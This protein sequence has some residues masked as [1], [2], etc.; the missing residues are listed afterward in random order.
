VAADGEDEEGA[1]ADADGT[2][3][4]DGAGPTTADDGGDADSDSD[5]AASSFF[6]GPP[7]G[8]DAADPEATR[9]GEGADADDGE[10]A[11]A[12]AA[13][14]E[15]EAVDAE[16]DVTVDA[17]RWPGEL[18]AAGEDLVEQ[19]HGA[20][21]A[22]PPKTRG[23]LRYYRKE[24]PAKPLDAHFAG[25]GDGDRTS[26][27]AHNRTLRTHGFIEHV[28]RG[29]YGYRLADLIEAEYGREPGADELDAL[30]SAVEDAFLK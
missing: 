24:G 15:A 10:V 19:L 16:D 1:T 12:M 20:I 9:N 26:A 22:M 18:P 17:E 23:M 29:Y 27:Y 30:V 3:A 4:A 5:T 11:A 13:V 7:G 14:G 25:G 28:G 6:D 8:T 21:E 2:A